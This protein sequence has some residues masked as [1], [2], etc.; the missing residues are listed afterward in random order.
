MAMK[1]KKSTTVKDWLP[2]VRAFEYGHF[3]SKYP[4]K[5]L[6]TFTSKESCNL[7][8]WNGIFTLFEIHKILLANTTD[9]TPQQYGITDLENFKNYLRYVVVFVTFGGFVQQR[10][11]Y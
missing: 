8:N 2:D 10:T 6:Q 9:Q 11:P 5:K 1:F 3:V 7:L 4:N